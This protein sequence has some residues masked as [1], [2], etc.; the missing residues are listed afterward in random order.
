MELLEFMELKSYA[1]AYFTPN[2]KLT[3]PIVIFEDVTNSNCALLEI[4]LLIVPELIYFVI[5]HCSELQDEDQNQ[6]F[7]DQVDQSQWS[8]VQM[9]KI[10]E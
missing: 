1:I 2:R 5:L 8:T 3:R 4:T 7:F 6:K 9:W 10:Q